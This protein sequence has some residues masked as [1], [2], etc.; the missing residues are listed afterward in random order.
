MSAGTRKEVFGQYIST[1]GTQ[2]LE[3]V[4]DPFNKERPW[5]IRA[6]QR[7]PGERQWGDS[8]VLWQTVSS[9]REDVDVHWKER[10]ARQKRSD[11]WKKENEA[12][13]NKHGVRA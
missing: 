5:R 13:R 6:S 1:D 10:I 12:F 7:L 11:Q 4:F 3:L 8:Y 2:R 9:T